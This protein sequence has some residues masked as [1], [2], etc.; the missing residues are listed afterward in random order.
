MGKRFN[1]TGTC[2]PQKHYMVNIE[3]KIS[4]I[5]NM[6]NNG[7]YFVINRLRQYGKT[8]LISRLSKSIESKYLVL[9][10]SFEGNGD[11]MFQSEETFSKEILDSLADNL[12]FINEEKSMELSNYLDIEALDK[13]YLL[14]FNF[15]KNKEYLSREYNF[16]KK[17]IFQVMV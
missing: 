14:I 11:V 13:G 8:T 9:R 12:E 3:N 15:N 7:D 5:E 10:T 17:E 2:I 16:E 1:T 6:I 4:Q